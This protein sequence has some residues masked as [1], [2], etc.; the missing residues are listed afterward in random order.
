MPRVLQLY[1]LGNTECHI[2]CTSLKHIFCA[3]FQ[4]NVD[5]SK[6]I[7]TQHADVLFLIYYMFR[8]NF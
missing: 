8:N 5:V 2:D 1:N 4:L 3:V 7:T 6:I